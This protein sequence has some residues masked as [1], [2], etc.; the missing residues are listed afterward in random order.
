MPKVKRRYRDAGNGEFVSKEEAEER[1]NETVSEKIE[2]P[3]P[4]GDDVQIRVDE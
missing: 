2:P 3:K 1:P 4:N